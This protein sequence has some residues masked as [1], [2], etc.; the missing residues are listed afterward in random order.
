MGQ[1]KL[2]SNERGFSL[3][4][5]LVVLAILGLLTAIVGPK[6]IGKLG[7]A[8]R[9]AAEIQIA[10]LGAA[11]D[12]YYLDVGNYPSKE[13]GLGALTVEPDGASG[14]NGPYLKKSKL[15]KDPWGNEYQYDFPGKNGAYDIVSFAAD[16]VL[17]GSDDGAD[18]A[19]WE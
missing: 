9:D 8:K 2:Q 3:I 12:L 16:G 10:D 19:S 1:R 15:P 14:W 5:L 13:Q 7:G 18:I 11:L 17:G 4:E 6:V